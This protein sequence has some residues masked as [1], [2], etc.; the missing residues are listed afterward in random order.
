MAGVSEVVF[1]ASPEELRAWLA[2][3]HERVRE[4][5]GAT[6]AVGGVLGQRQLHRGQVAAAVFI[7]SVMA[8]ARTSSAPRKMPGKQ[9]TLLIWLG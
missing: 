6:G 9:R 4:G 8:W 7:S 1:F 2:E 5:A 3:H